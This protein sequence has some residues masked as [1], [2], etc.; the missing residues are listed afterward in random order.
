MIVASWGFLGGPL[1]P[2]CLQSCPGEPAATAA[3]TTAA[4]MDATGM[5]AMGAL[6]WSA[7]TASMFAATFF[8]PLCARG[9]VLG[10]NTRLFTVSELVRRAQSASSSSD[11][12]EWVEIESGSELEPPCTTVDSTPDVFDIPAEAARRGW[13]EHELT[14][15]V[16][17]H[18]ASQG[19]RMAEFCLGDGHVRAGFRPSTRSRSERMGRA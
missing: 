17:E 6:C 10:T 3:A 4:L 7:T 1:G 16:F 8:Q 14:H 9:R 12:Y 11:L 13:C 19:L 15:Y 2:D 18:G 5:A